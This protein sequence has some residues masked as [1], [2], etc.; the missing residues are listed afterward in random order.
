MDIAVVPMKSR[1]YMGLSAASPQQIALLSP[2]PIDK[3]V[4]RRILA[5]TPDRNRPR[6]ASWMIHWSAQG[7]PLSVDL[8][9]C[10]SALFADSRDQVVRD[11]FTRR[12]L[13]RR[14]CRKRE[15]GVALCRM[16]N[17]RRRQRQGP[18]YLSSGPRSP[19]S[20]DHASQLGYWR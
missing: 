13:G 17:T 10:E 19:L 9:R 8:F 20:V 14:Q 15:T 12:L 2:F 18:K 6:G 5:V 3:D 11:Q 16:V 1:N 4:V 7:Q